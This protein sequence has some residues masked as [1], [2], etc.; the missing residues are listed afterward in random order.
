MTSR[1]AS[2]LVLMMLMARVA[3]AQGEIVVIVNPTSGVEA[4]TR[5]DAVNIFMGR[6]QKLPSGIAALPVDERGV[7]SAFYR[8][9]VGKALPE[10]QSYWARLV[11]S[12]QGSPP[13][14]LDSADDVLDLVANNKGAI[15]YVEKT[16][17]TS[18]V[19]VVF[20]LAQ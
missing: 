12:G 6:Y 9:L 10:I 4:L 3:C 16:K 15:G 8:R 11:F 13:R 1:V 20:D 18:R 17:V 2:V 14:Q 5:D 19:K 7:K